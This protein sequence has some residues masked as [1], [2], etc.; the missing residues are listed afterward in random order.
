MGNVQLT[1]LALLHLHRNIPA[2]NIED[3]VD[4]FAR[5]QTRGLKMDTC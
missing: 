5:H 4:E 2:N 1:G 3:V